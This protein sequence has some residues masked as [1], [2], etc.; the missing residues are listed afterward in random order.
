MQTVSDSF[1]QFHSKSS[2]I[3]FD[4]AFKSTFGVHF[5]LLAQGNGMT[6]LNFVFDERKF[7]QRI[8]FSLTI[9]RLHA[10]VILILLF[11]L[12]CVLSNHQPLVVIRGGVFSVT[13]SI[14]LFLLL[15]V[16]FFWATET[17]QAWQPSSIINTTTLAFFPR[18]RSVPRCW[19][20]QPCLLCLHLSCM[21]LPAQGIQ[22][23][24]ILRPQSS[25]SSQD[26]IYSSLIQLT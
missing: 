3:G 5:L 4:P 14:F 9:L 2:L 12:L 26:G 19:W 15:A 18:L 16:L 25:C 21:M 17:I 23:L 24:L 20:Q 11:L 13:S 8:N 7:I 22:T 10:G 1:V 6:N